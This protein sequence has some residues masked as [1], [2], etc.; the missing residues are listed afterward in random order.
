M[1][2]FLRCLQLSFPAVVVSE[3]SSLL[4][5]IFFTAYV[6]Y[7]AVFEASLRLYLLLFVYTAKACGKT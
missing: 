6:S 5:R 4:S 3:R 2:P 7:F 1:G